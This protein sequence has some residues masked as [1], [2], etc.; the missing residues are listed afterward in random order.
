[1]K[2]FGRRGDK[3]VLNSG[4]VNANLNWKAFTE[5]AFVESYACSLFSKLNNDICLPIS[6]SNE[7]LFSSGGGDFDGVP[8]K[9]VGNLDN[10]RRI[11]FGLFLAKGN[12]VVAQVKISASKNGYFISE[13]PLNDFATI[14]GKDFEI[15]K[16]FTMEPVFAV[17]ELLRVPIK[18]IY[19][20]YK[21]LFVTA[22]AVTGVFLGKKGLNAIF[23]GASP[24][25][26]SEMLENAQKQFQNAMKAGSG[27]VDAED[28]FFTFRMEVAQLRDAIDFARVELATL[29][30]I[31]KNQLT[32]EQYTNTLGSAGAE[33]IDERKYRRVLDEIR[34]K[35]LFPMLKHFQEEFSYEKFNQVEKFDLALAYGNAT[36]MIG[37]PEILELL[38]Q[39][40][41]EVLEK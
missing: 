7:L 28:K 5:E 34:E 14:G 3:G 23:Q 2:I 16:T 22:G 6:G 13:K 11:V 8:N 27:V 26:M 18:V 1:M 21:S 35:Y 39:E 19:N 15:L 32:G 4:E 25:A 12:V 24:H 33:L 40:L 37:D 30:G 31:P 29:L 9:L 10:L 17:P 36:R 20:N 38:K 41:L